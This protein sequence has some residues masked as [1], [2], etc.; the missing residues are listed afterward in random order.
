[1]Q[2]Y[3]VPSVSFS[4]DASG[5]MISRTEV[6]DTGWSSQEVAGGQISQRI[7]MEWG[8]TDVSYYYAV[9]LVAHLKV[10]QP[11]KTSFQMLPNVLF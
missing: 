7:K 5:C 9:G 2:E 10:G 8:E 1:V 6:L 4:K 11:R 3:H